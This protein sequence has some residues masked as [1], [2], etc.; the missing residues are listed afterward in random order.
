[1]PKSLRIRTEVGVDKYIN[2][3]LEQDFEMIEIL[4]LKILTND[5]YTRYCSDYG[6]IVGR[7]SVN[8]GYGVPNARVSV[9]I[10]LQDED[11]DNPVVAEL[12]PYVNLT[13]R[14]E[15]GYR[16]NLLP[17]EPSYIG[18]QPTGTFPTR[19]DVL[20][21]SSY[22]E[23]Y[24]RYYRFTVKTNESGDFMIFGVPIG[25]QT[26]VMDVDLSDI[27]CF[28]LSPQDLI[29]QGV[30][31]EAQVN[32]AQFK[33]SSNLDSLPQI[34]NLN[35]NV[36][37]RPLWGDVDLCQLGITRVDFDLTK[38]ANIVIEPYAVFMGSLVSTT[39]DDSLSI[40]CR[41]KNDTGNFC[42]LVAGPGQILAIRQTIF[43]DTTG[44]PILEQYEFEDNGKII[45]ENGTFVASVPMN[46]NYIVT[47]EF[48]DQIF[49]N[50]PSKGIPTKGKYR[51]KFRWINKEKTLSINR[52]QQQIAK[53]K[54]EVGLS[55][56]EY[57]GQYQRASF[58]VP[59]IK[60]YGWQNSAND[61]LNLP[62]QTIT[63]QVPPPP[64]GP[65]PYPAQTGPTI[66]IPNNV[67]WQFVSATNNISYE[68]WIDYGTGSGFQPYLGGVESIALPAGSQ[69]YIVGTPLAIN[70]QNFTFNE[71][72]QNKFDLFRSYAFSLDWDDYADFQSAIDCE[73]TFYEFNYNKVYTTALFLDRYKNGLGRAKHLGIKEIDNRTCKTENNT[74]PVN[75]IIRNFD[76]IF[77][78]FNI[79][80]IILLPL[81]LV[82]LFLAHFLAWLWPVIKWLIVFVY[83][84]LLAYQGY[85]V[86]LAYQDYQN[87]MLSAFIVPGP[88]PFFIPI[89]N[90]VLAASCQ[91]ALVA[92]IAHAALMIAF[93]TL[94]GIILLQWVQRIRIF[95]R[96][97]L[98]LINYP[99]CST[100]E[101]DC[102]TIEMDDDFDTQSVQG[103]LDTIAQSA[104]QN[105]TNPTGV[106]LVTSAG[107]LA[108]V[109]ISGSYTVTHPNYYQNPQG[110]TNLNDGPFYCGAPSLDFQSIEY[111]IQQNT[112]DTNVVIRASQDFQR[113][114]S[115]YDILSSSNSIK[116]TSNEK[117]LL[118]APQPFLFASKQAS[119]NNPDRRWFAFPLTAT[120][121][122]R[123]NE[124]NTRDKYFS[125]VNRIQTTINPQIVGSGTFED[126]VLVILA[127]P[128]TRLQLTP[129]KLFT[130]Q[131]P[132][133]FDVNS[134]IRLVN[135][136]GASLN[137]FA[138]NSVTGVTFTG[139]TGITIN[140]A[141]PTVPN[142]SV[143]TSANVI[144]TADAITQVV[145]LANNGPTTPG[146]NGY[147]QSFLKFATDLEYFQAITGLTVTN[148]LNQSNTANNTLFPRGYLLHQIKYLR[149]GCNLAGIPS[150]NYV[151]QTVTT[152][153]LQLIQNFGNY[154]VIIC[155]RGVDPHSQKQNIRYDLS[156]IFGNLGSGFK[157][158][159]GPYYPNVPIQAYASPSQVTQ[160]SENPITHY[161]TDNNGYDLYFPSYSFTISPQSAINPNYT[162]FTSNLPYYYLAT[163]DE[164]F[165][166]GNIFSQLYNPGGFNSFSTVLISPNMISVNSNYGVPWNP[167]PPLPTTYFVG[168]SFIGTNYDQDFANTFPLNYFG[169]L[170]QSAALTTKQTQY[171]WNTVTNNALPFPRLNFVYSPAY[172]RV[173]NTSPVTFSQRNYHFMRSDRIPTSTKTQDGTAS[174]TGYGLHQNDNFFY[175]D[176]EGGEPPIT[177]TTGQD[178]SDA[179]TL[180]APNIIT[181]LTETLQCEGIV[182]L[183]CYSGDGYTWGIIPY[184]QCSV[185]ANIVKNGC[186]CLLNKKEDPSSPPSTIFGIQ[187]NGPKFLVNG[188]F[189]ADMRLLYEWKVRF[190]MNFALCRGVFAQ[191]FQNNWVNGVLYMFSFNTR[192]IFGLD[193]N[194]PLY[195]TQFYK[196]YCNDVIVYN[197]ITN[198]FYYRSSPWN[199]VISEFIGKNP[200]PTS[201]YPLNLLNINGPGYNKKQIQ[202]PT[203]VVDLGPRDSFIREICSNDAFG[204]YYCDQ[205]DTT[206]YKDN[207][208]ILLL[209]FLSRLLNLQVSNTIQPS[210]SQIAITEGQ[211]ISQFFDNNRQSWRIDGDIAQ[212]LS[213]N[214]EWKVSPF[215]TENLDP[216]TANQYVFLG[217]E[218]P[219]FVSKP[220]F[221]VF[222]SSSTEELR[223]RK[224]MS[225]GIE[226][227][228][229]TPI[230]QEIFGYSKS[231]EVP[232]YRWLISQSPWI[233]G[234]ENNNW[235]TDVLTTGFFKKKYQDL[236][237]FSLNE[238][239]LTQYNQSQGGFG[240]ITNFNQPPL[241]PN[242]QPSPS[243]P[244]PVGNSGVIQG[245]PIGS[246]T[247]TTG[248][249]QSVVVGA[250]YH[251]YF[252]LKN[253]ATAVDRF[254][255]L[256]VPE[257]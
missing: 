177:V 187:I 51:F 122:Q 133:Y 123:L 36:D 121:P 145:S 201:Q 117:D 31:T 39:N 237:F 8:N 55:D 46:L 89:V 165:N 66:F 126:E 9:F 206:S 85:Q 207:S 227:Y 22:V 209:G 197:D 224:I 255:K 176:T 212:M 45:D 243:F 194:Q 1:M 26:V 47:N 189:Q 140:Y 7:V 216:A 182:P 154:E 155:T 42:E 185:P 12:Y 90:P 44:K 128:G 71:I 83:L 146:V 169:Y 253:G 125:G 97:G 4:S 160:T 17:K 188:A 198:N 102:G 70:P 61:P 28:S 234:T 93:F 139:T 113:L 48:G 238:K 184:S 29:Q 120:Y 74:F 254:Y 158:V 32:S 37:V 56:D 141:D 193:P 204:S 53:Q 137:D 35:F 72:P 54:K 235:Y 164:S 20:M 58:L 118:H 88:P 132:N 148:F 195:N 162:G 181:A 232:H 50:D 217:T 219:G 23:V 147:E 27:G 179:S 119:G 41:P 183:A 159:E 167:V 257:F 30:A 82:I 75:D 166:V 149:P 64:V 240:F 135:L 77:F 2:L 174:Q 116:M 247:Q 186:Y 143:Q 170:T 65:P 138:T 80:M 43:S 242:P 100:C 57:S 249:Q 215:I 92:A 21:D 19:A 115:G 81:A 213:I 63:Y 52:F 130:F 229:Q 103:Q 18:H 211:S 49:S 91:Q 94:A 79:L 214:S 99:D 157:V 223:Y 199:S 225:P 200:P 153:A 127:K 226:T 191:V 196:S 252:G 129:G 104:S 111:S 105:L 38:F 69:V 96:I 244:P 134:S 60:E 33:T 190:T 13:S 14:N 34:V 180:D 150:N 218:S 144:M 114:F 84:F 59:N 256:Y 222:F 161:T 241:P 5:L 15:Q 11:I 112:I 246:P 86:Y 10:P 62:N 230:I 245:Q 156:R 3:D 95:P 109:G 202:F 173:Y 78:V 106:Q 236:N 178:T 208:N 233:F 142:G 25:E 228:S 68:I 98:P 205:L 231:Q 24:D 108:P 203:T 151:V 248:K 192:K 40:A 124:F 152:P 16:Y 251:F 175:Y 250:P 171:F 87:C 163:D 107:F 73:D 110:S 239:Y 67:G 6:V 76:L 172:Y 220:V 101:C 221:G 136:T 210:G 168:G 131:D